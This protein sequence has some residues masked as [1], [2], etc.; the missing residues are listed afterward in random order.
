MT[1]IFL[2]YARNDDEPFVNRLHA[3]LDHVALLSVVE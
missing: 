2:S 3:D 1:A